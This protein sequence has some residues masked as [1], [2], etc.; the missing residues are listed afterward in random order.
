MLHPGLCS[1]SFRKHTVDE[2][3]EFARSAGIEGIEWGG[4]VHLPP[5]DPGLARSVRERTEAAGLVVS[6]YGSYHRSDGEAGPFSP[7]VE[8]AAALGAPVIRVWAGRRGSADAGRPYRSEVAARLREAAAA[9]RG[10]NITVALEYH[11]GTLTDTR[12]SAHRLLEEAGDPDL[13]LF[14]QPRTG[15]TFENDLAEL[16][17]ALPR[18][19]HV[20]CFHWGPGGWKDRKPLR[21]GTGDW[22]RYLEL[23]RR[24]EGDRFVIL[25]FIKDDSPGQFR[26]D[27]G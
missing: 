2:I 9:A 21:E 5:G 6:S 16:E 27:A 20:H 10:R 19:S 25:E 22:K 8:S 12:E 14:W 24:A 17:A 1:I 26:E 13:K 23:I 11:G 4:D 3:I 7:V 15:G 18:L